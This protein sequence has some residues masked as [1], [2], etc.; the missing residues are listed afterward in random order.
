[1]KAFQRVVLVRPGDS[2]RLLCGVQN[3]KKLQV[4]RKAH[5]LLLNCHRTLRAFPRE[6]GSLKSQLRR[7]AESVPTNIVEGCG[8]L[9]QKEFARFLQSSASSSNELEY[10]LLVARDYGLLDQR[11][12]SSL[13]RDTQEVS[14]MLHGLLEKVRTSIRQPRDSRSTDPS[15]GS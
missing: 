10:H 14:R 8:F 7:A 6:Y 9:S 5:A 1:L 3:Y 13:T 12:W 15:A 11:T 4:W 2:S